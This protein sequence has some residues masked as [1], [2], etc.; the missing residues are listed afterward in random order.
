MGQQVL[1]EVLALINL[2]M[3]TD[4]EYLSGARWYR[5]ARVLVKRLRNLHRS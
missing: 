5:E 4:K 3:V 1:H 2:D